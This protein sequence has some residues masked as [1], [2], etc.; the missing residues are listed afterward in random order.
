MDEIKVARMGT[1]S[2]KNTFKDG[3]A[4][5]QKAQKDFQA[6]CTH[7]PWASVMVTVDAAAAT[8]AGVVAAAPFEFLTSLLDFP[9]PLFLP[10]PSLLFLPLPSFPFPPLSPP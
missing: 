7:C 9:S 4:L 10:L 6:S 5:E 3:N 1:E 2:F 8:A